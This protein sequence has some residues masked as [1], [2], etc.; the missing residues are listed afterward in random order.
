MVS[1]EMSSGTARDKL[2][3][4]FYAA[5]HICLET[6]F[7]NCCGTGSSRIL[8]DGAPHGTKAPERLSDSLLPTCSDVMNK[9]AP[10]AGSG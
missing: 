10:N 2:D 1:V 4:P 9:S 6:T 3:L 8:K 5:F 7:N